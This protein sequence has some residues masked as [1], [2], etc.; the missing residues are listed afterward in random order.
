MVLRKTKT[1]CITNSVRDNNSDSI[2]ELVHHSQMQMIMAEEEMVL[3]GIPLENDQKNSKTK[4]IVHK[5]ISKFSLLN[6]EKEEQDELCSYK[7]KVSRSS[8]TITIDCNE[9]EHESSLE[10]EHCRKNIFEILK[11]EPAVDRLTLAKLYE[12]DYEGR[13]LNAIYLMAGL[14]DKFIPYKNISFITDNCEN[15][16]LC[17]KEHTKI[18]DLI[19]SG[20]G[21]DPLK[22]CYDVKKLIEYNEKKE[23]HF[24]IRDECSHCRQRF[25]NTLLEM[26]TISER[27]T[28]CI[29]NRT[30]TCHYTD[31]VSRCDQEY[32][33]E[34]ERQLRSYVRPPFSTSRIYAEPPDNTLFLECYEIS[35]QDERH[36]PVNIYQLTD[37]PEKMYIINPIEYSLEEKELKLIERIRKK[38]IAHRPADLQF[39][40][41]GNSRD[42]FQRLSKKFLFEENNAEEI[43]SDPAKIKLYC[44]LLT[45]Y[46]TGLGILEDILSDERVTDVY[47]NAPADQN[48][49]HVVLGGEECVSNIYLSQE[50]MESMVSRLRSIS[51]R[52]FGEATPV[53]EMFLRE[54][55]VRVSVIGDPLSAKGIAYAFR[56]HAKDPWTLPKLI[57]KGSIS[58]LTAGLLSF[59]MDGQ[60]SVL[61]AGGVGAGKTSLMSALLLEMPQKYRMITIEDTPEIPIE[62]LQEMGWKVQGLNSQS[63][64]MKYGVEIEPSVALRA[65]LR[66]GSS[67]LIMGEVRGPEV[68]VLY[69]AMQVGAAGNSVIGTIHGSSTDAVYERI[70]N[71][72]EVPPASFKATDAVIVCAN[73]RLSGS[74]TMKRRVMQVAEVN[75][76]WDENSGKVF[77]DILSYDASTDKLVSSDIMDKG[78]SVLIGKIADKWGISMDEAALNIRM[79]AEIKGKIAK[80]GLR[81]PHLL[82]ARNVAIANN[83][84]WMLMDKEVTETD[85]SNYQRVYDRW[86]EWF[87]S[88]AGRINEKAVVSDELSENDSESGVKTFSEKKAVL[89]VDDKM[90]EESYDLITNEDYFM[91]GGQA[92]Q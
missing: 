31:S 80:F 20:A 25:L 87:S 67:S 40:D 54:Y 90:P 75:E 38:M 49:V 78:Q 70:V 24:D 92:V 53:L 86:F 12:R 23:K 22:S 3:L 30:G 41:S 48:P 83:M 9:C 15:S 55:G 60:A 77:S 8:R 47:V 27:I 76:K 57:N 36:L 79:R 71:T 17:K 62:E 18:M 88:F 7:S 16:G 5:L 61:V 50:D 10:S 51:G 66:L 2:A 43:T 74:M 89:S 34:Y 44:D 39:A 65:S 35:Y 28:S 21:N 59:I 4:K 6:R 64:I 11:K 42:Y 82:E 91:E 68:A 46:T 81:Q 58:P 56:K 84:F 52:P 33:A 85:G 19:V 1:T 26:K 45:K 14:Q 69:E 13:S 72:L 37:R 63:A 29:G 73:T 32:A